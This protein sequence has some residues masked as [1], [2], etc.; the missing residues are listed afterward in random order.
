M[1]RR[2][3]QKPNGGQAKGRVAPGNA[4]EDDPTLNPLPL[5]EF[6]ERWPISHH[7][8]RTTSQVGR[9]LVGGIPVT[10]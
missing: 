9:D 2:F 10:A 8:Y 6:N 1:I 3:G 5:R 4:L 7:G